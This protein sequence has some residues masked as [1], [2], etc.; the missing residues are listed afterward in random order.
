MATRD[1]PFKNVI[2][3]INFLIV[4][5]QRFRIRRANNISNFE[6]VNFHLAE[7]FRAKHEVKSI[8]T[9][10]IHIEECFQPSNKAVETECDVRTWFL[11]INQEIFH[12]MN[13]LRSLVVGEIYGLG[14]G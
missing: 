2:R 7:I 12:L 9:V 10:Y 8:G 14:A 11:R 4:Y 5:L 3:L 13:S 1:R 6:S